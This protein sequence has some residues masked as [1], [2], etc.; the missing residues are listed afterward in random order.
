MVDA[1]LSLLQNTQLLTVFVTVVFLKTNVYDSMS[2]C[3]TMDLMQR[4]LNHLEKE[5]LAFPGNFD[6]NFYLKGIQIALDIDHSI[7]VPRTL[8]LIYRTLHFFPLEYRSQIILSLLHPS[9]FHTLLFSWSYNIR[10]IFLSLLL[11]QVEYL[12]LNARNK[13][14]KR[15]NKGGI[16]TRRNAEKEAY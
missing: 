5:T 4:W 15:G 6:F 10:D 14:G 16:K 3:A 8:Y 7:S 13:G 11:Y 9:R 12:Y 2:V 1:T